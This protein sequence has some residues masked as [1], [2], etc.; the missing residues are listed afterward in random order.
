MADWKTQISYNYNP[1]FH[2]YAYGLVY[3]P[4]PEQNHTGWGD[5]APADYSNFSPGMTQVYYAASARTREESPPHSPEQ[6]VANGHCHYQSS[7][8]VY[9]GESQASRLLLAGPHRAV[10]DTPA[11]E[12]RRAGSDSTSDSEAHASPDSWSFGCN[13]EGSLPQADP[14]K[15]A[16]KEL[17]DEAD[18]R[19]PDAGDVSSSLMGEPSS[20][21][22]IGNPSCDTF[23]VQVPLTTP[24]K[25]S[26]PSEKPKC[27][28]RAAF[29]ESQMNA[30]VQRFSVQ[31]Y[32]TPAEMKNLAEL[33]GLTYKQ[34][35]TWF[36]NRRMKLR[37]HQKDTWVS[38]RYAN[39]GRRSAL[40]SHGPPYPPESERPPVKERY[41]HPMVDAAFKTT[42]PQ[43]LSFYLA[44]M[45]STN[46]A[47]AGYPSW[48]PGQAAM[49][50]AW[51]MPP[52]VNQYEYNPNGFHSSVNVEPD[53]HFEAKD[54]VDPVTSRI[55]LNS[56]CT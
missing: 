13:R 15:W 22:N 36:Q 23:P 12:S 53:D 32:L 50:T 52:G 7:A 21:T 37:R 34:V 5:G 11:E 14:T 54:G 17:S 29:S 28:V 45:G 30:L 33:T 18:S 10:C 9:F 20:Y 4:G 31:R 38:E 48:M 40:V 19:S 47:G 46:G 49:P 24:K 6:H 35:K 2:A 42:T 3:Q 39:K 1:S 8:V 51:S 26:T 41:T 55:V 56:H 43:N 16:K 27:K 44:S 25:G